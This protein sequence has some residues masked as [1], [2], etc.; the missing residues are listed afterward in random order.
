MK[1]TNRIRRV[2]TQT[3]DGYFSSGLI[4]TSKW[5]Q[6][7]EDSPYCGSTMSNPQSEQSIRN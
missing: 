5:N 6:R 2:T 7:G 3:G 1:G 4:R